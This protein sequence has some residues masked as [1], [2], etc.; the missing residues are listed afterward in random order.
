MKTKKCAKTEKNVPW[1]PKRLQ[2]E[3][4]EAVTGYL[5]E[6]HDRCKVIMACGTGKTL[7]AMWVVERR[8]DRSVLVLVPSLSLIAGV[9]E[10]W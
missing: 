10:E 2:G 7:T 5:D 3:A 4:I 6:H 1:V 9:I 8:D